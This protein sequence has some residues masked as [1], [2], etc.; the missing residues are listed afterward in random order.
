MCSVHIAWHLNMQH[1]ETVTHCPV[2]I[3]RMVGSEG[4]ELARGYILSPLWKVVLWRFRA[5]DL[6]CRLG[7]K[8]D[9]YDIM[10]YSQEMPCLFFGRKAGQLQG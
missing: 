9:G 8:Y 5:K 2:A 3:E 7:G 10:Y 6:S 1:G 4:V